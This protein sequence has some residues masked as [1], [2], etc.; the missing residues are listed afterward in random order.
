MLLLE[1]VVEGPPVSH[2]ARDKD[3]LRDWRLRVRTAALQRWPS[4]QLPVRIY[5]L[6]I[7]V[8]FFHDGPTYRMDNDNMVKPIQ[9]ALQ[10]L[11]YDDDEQITDTIVR[12]RDLNAP[13]RVRGMSPVMASGFATA[14]EFL[15]IRVDE[16]SDHAEPLLWLN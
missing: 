12:R 8:V 16:A 11:V 7:V 14:R 4:G 3:L 15:Y 6:R 9:D 1:F 2:Q 5:G 13:H 10:S